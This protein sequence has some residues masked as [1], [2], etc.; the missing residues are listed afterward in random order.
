[1]AALAACR[2]GGLDR[3]L[4]RAATHDAR[5]LRALRMPWTDALARVLDAGIALVIGERAQARE[6]LERAH[7]EFIAAGM[8]LYAMLVRRRLGE[9]DGGAEGAHAITEADAWL[10]AQ[11]VRAP[12]RL[13]RIFMPVVS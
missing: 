11:G 7:A 10:I 1:V 13:T 2:S 12:E 6:Q 3:R 5:G 9:L 8:M 4:I